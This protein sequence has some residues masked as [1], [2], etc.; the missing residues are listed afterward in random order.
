M[1]ADLPDPTALDPGDAYLV[2][3]TG[4][5]WVVSA[6]PPNH[7]INGGHLQ[8]PQGVPGSQGIPGNPGPPGQT[9]P[10]GDKGNTGNP[11]PQGLQGVPGT[12]GAKGDAGSPGAQGPKGDAGAAGAQG[13]KGDTGA[14][15][16]QGPIGPQGPPGSG[17]DLDEFFDPVTGDLLL[18]LVPD[19]PADTITSGTFAYD[20]MPAGTTFT[21]NK[22]SGGTWPARPSANPNLVWQWIGAAPGPV[23][24]T[25]GAINGD[26]WL[27]DQS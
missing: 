3:A 27:E 20:L 9:G 13:P 12:Q 10:K 25:G 15:G 18:D 14:A 7:W 5:I 21:I 24:G 2:N 26:I 8:G 22:T 19:L 1:V 11:G 6:G 16:P 4:D 17:G 23:I